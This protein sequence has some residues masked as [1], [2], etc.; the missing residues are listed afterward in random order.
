MDQFKINRIKSI[1]FEV[2]IKAFMSKTKIMYIFSWIFLMSSS[3][4]GM[5]T[6][7]IKPLTYDVIIPNR[8][9]YTKIGT[10]D[11]EMGKFVSENSKSVITGDIGRMAGITLSDPEEKIPKDTIILIKISGSTFPKKLTASVMER[12]LSNCGHFD[13]MANS[14]GDVSDFVSLVSSFKFIK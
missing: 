6:D 10:M 7:S 3:M 14:D 9:I 5:E 2:I 8:Y 4:F 11:S 13:M 12:N 1:R